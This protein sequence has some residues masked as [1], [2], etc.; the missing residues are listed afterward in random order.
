MNFTKKKILS[1]EE[2]YTNLDWCYITDPDFRKRYIN[3]FMS[4]D[5]PYGINAVQNITKPRLPPIKINGV[6]YTGL[7]WET[8]S[9]PWTVGPYSL[10]MT[11]GVMTCTPETNDVALAFECE[12]SHS[13]DTMPGLPYIIEA[14][15]AYSLQDSAEGIPY[16]DD[17]LEAYKLGR[18]LIIHGTYPHDSADYNGEAYAEV[19]S[20]QI[21]SD[22]ERDP[23]TKIEHSSFTIVLSSELPQYNNSC[24]FYCS[25]MTEYKTKG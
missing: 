6:I 15:K 20:V 12:I 3:W 9:F 8:G 23:T 4:V 14:E 13:Y 18:R 11:K 22:V 16:A 24:S 7:R 17:I 5:L 10:N 25:P 2:T 21:F 19:G 1:C